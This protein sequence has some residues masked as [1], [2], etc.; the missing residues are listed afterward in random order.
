MDAAALARGW[1]EAWVRMDMVWLRHRLHPDFVHES[2]FGRLEGRDLYLETVEPLAR[3]SVR[4]L[5]IID[6]LADGERAAIRFVNRTAEGE[7]PS[8][9]WL[10]VRD[11]LILD[12]RSFYD[13]SAVR[14]VLTSDEQDRLGGHGDDP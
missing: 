4:E 14:S 1:I 5:R 11:G 10:R 9:D 3:K 7:V 13:A 8:C 12:I 6:V 2:P